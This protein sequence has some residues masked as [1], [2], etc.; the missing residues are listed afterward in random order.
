MHKRHIAKVTARRT[1]CHTQ[2][3]ILQT[4]EQVVLAWV[5]EVHHQLGIG[6]RV[7]GVCLLRQE[8]LVLLLSEVGRERVMLL[9]A[10]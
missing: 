1:T 2:V 4:V 6:E 5:H 10:G 8:H 7:H 3:V 9:L